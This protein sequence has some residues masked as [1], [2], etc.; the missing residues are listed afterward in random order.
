MSEEIDTIKTTITETVSSP[1]KSTEDPD[2][3]KTTVS[4][5]TKTVSEP[6]EIATAKSYVAILKANALYPATS[7]LLHW[8]DPV[9]TGLIFGV[10]NFFFFLTYLGDYSFLTMFSYLFLTLLTI[11]FGY[12]NYVVLKASW[13]QGK[14]VENPFT[15]RFKNAKFHVSRDA[16]EHHL[17]TVLDLVNTTID[18]F[19][20]VF[21]CTDNFLSL[22]F[23]LYFWVAA[24]VGNWFSG[25]VIIYLAM[26][27]FFIWPRLYEEKKKEIDQFYNIALVQGNNYY[28]LALTKL[29]PAVHQ[30][31]PQLKPK[32]N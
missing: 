9:K 20:D 12:S 29:P 13:L 3:I 5:S 4:K 15:E 24:T 7:K 14:V 18:N 26:L 31:F 17:T 28:Q 8:K 27:G 10:F 16:A 25:A 32:S 22:R 1:V 23:A 21:Y 6:T 30:K 11:C 19:R 2:E